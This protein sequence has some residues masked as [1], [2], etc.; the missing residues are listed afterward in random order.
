MPIAR[1][2]ISPIAVPMPINYFRGDVRAPTIRPVV[3]VSTRTADS[4]NLNDAAVSLCGLD[5]TKEREKHARDDSCL[6][7]AG[8]R[9]FRSLPDGI[10]RM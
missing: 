2:S 7:S 10:P 9:R 8:E 5:Q 3:C 1:G 4:L 6:L